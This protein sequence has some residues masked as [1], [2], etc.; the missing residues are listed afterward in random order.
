MEWHA[1][2]TRGFGHDTWMR[3][4]FL[5]EWADPR[6]VAALPGIFAHYD[7]G[8]IG[9]ALLATMEV[10]HWLAMETAERWSYTRWPWF[11]LSYLRGFEPGQV[12]NREAL[13][14]AIFW[15]VVS[16]LVDLIGWVLIRHPWALT[17]HEFYVEYQPWITL[18]YLVIFA[19]PIAVSRLMHQPAAASHPQ[20]G[21][22]K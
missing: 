1:H 21:F 11:A 18:I 16:M 20:A 19:T 13:R 2:A 7:A 10:F 12:R 3:G 6:A 5:E 9:R 17:F 8:D 4:R 22:P 15:T 14:L